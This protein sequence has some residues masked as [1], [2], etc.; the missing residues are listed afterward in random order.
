MG[1]VA[2]R[3]QRREEGNPA[4][5]DFLA[6]LE[7]E[8]KH[9]EEELAGIAAYKRQIQRTVP[10]QFPSQT[11]VIAS[12]AATAEATR[13]IRSP[14]QKGSGVVRGGEL[15]WRGQG[16]SPSTG[17]ISRDPG[18]SPERPGTTKGAETAKDRYMLRP[19]HHEPMSLGSVGSSTLSLGGNEEEEL[20]AH[21]A[22][23]QPPEPDPEQE[24]KGQRTRAFEGA[25]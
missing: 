4:T 8:N 9:L 6:Q 19:P 23:M 1:V 25:I 11:G 13:G 2:A 7:A 12:Q 21:S 22:V 3:Q 24:S 18:G 15:G 5:T 17:K 10:S 20:R 16:G 14:G